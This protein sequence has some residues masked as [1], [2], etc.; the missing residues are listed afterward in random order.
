VI[1]K[2]NIIMMNEYKQI[3][4]ATNEA[5]SSLYDPSCPTTMALMMRATPCFTKGVKTDPVCQGCPLRS[6]CLGEKEEI[7]EARKEARKVKAEIIKMG[8]D[9]GV[10]LKKIKIPRSAGLSTATVHEVKC[11]VTCVLSGDIIKQGEQAT[12]IPSMGWAQSDVLALVLD[13]RN[14]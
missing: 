3:E 11:D 2:E 12:F 14:A 10:D 9:R 5:V 8:Q 1:E 13:Y 4:N 6:A 7:K